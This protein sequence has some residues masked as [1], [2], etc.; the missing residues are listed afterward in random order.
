MRVIYVKEKEIK[1][2]ISLKWYYS[3]NCVIVLKEYEDVFD[4][5]SRLLYKDNDP[6][7]LHKILMKEYK[8][9]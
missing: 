6:E 3:A 8:F 5:L 2:N 7:N 4:F 9:E 1:L